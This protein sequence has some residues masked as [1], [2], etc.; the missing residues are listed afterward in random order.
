MQ[1]RTV[2][3]VNGRARGIYEFVSGKTTMPTVSHIPPQKKESNWILA[4]DSFITMST[5]SQT[6][7]L[8]PLDLIPPKYYTRL[9]LSFRT[10][11]PVSA[12]LPTLQASLRETCRSIP[13]LAGKVIST[14]NSTT[15]APS[16]QVG[17]NESNSPTMVDL[18]SLPRSY[19]ATAAA[20]MPLSTIPEG[21][22]PTPG[23]IDDQLH[24]AGAPVFSGGLL[25]FEVSQGV[26]LCVC[27]HHSVVDAGGMAQV[28]RIWTDIL[29]GK[30]APAI[31]PSDRIARLSEALQPYM[32]SA[33]ALRQ[34]DL[35]ASQPGYTNVPLQFNA[36][37][38]IYTSAILT[39]SLSKVNA[40][41]ADLAEHTTTA[42][43]TNTIICAV[44]WYAITRTR[45][46]RNP[47]LFPPDC[48]S[49]LG[50]PVDSRARIDPGFSTT[51]NPFFGNA[52]VYALAELETDGPN[53]TPENATLD[54]LLPL[55]AAI[56][57]SI[58]PDTINANTIAGLYTLVS[59]C[60]NSPALFPAWSIASGRD[61]AITSW[62]NLGLYEMRF[63]DGLGGAEFVRI[64]YTKLDSAANILPRRRRAEAAGNDQAAADVL[65]VVV[66]L[67][68]D[69]LKCLRN[70]EM[71][72]RIVAG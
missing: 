2:V 62:A 69:D 5:K 41:K 9:A 4:P 65:E 32:E 66:M 56:A 33:S 42:F 21:K 54:I 19:V 27:I 58:S 31:A 29:C 34:E 16:V 10:T 45:Q 17:W 26:I 35:L 12:I 71:W 52:Y 28:F 72:A 7:R 1:G 55:C 36:D 20:G 38:T 22:W 70:N 15:Q 11:E 23:R 64:P 37:F 8:S 44:L 43:T 6:L 53:S 63:G 60:A 48:K 51:K 49:K 47:T 24:K 40:L 14:N 67:R 30:P 39:I 61:L 25:S 3:G 50:M 68:E 46:K 18:G 13:W 59:R 57:A